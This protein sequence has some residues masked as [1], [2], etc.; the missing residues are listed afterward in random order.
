MRP[1]AIPLLLLVAACGKSDAPRMQNADT[2]TQR[3][4][5]S[6][7]GASGLPGAQGI[8]KAQAAQDSANARTA[9]ADSIARADTAQ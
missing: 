7:I 5:D 1:S 8:S 6:V 4:R 9:R 3:Q 2:L